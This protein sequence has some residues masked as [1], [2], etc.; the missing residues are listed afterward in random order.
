GAEP[1]VVAGRGCTASPRRARAGS[2][3]PRTA[4]R[5]ARADRPA[6][7]DRRS[8]ALP[9]PSQTRPAFLL[10][11]SSLSQPPVKSHVPTSTAQIARLGSW[12]LWSWDLSRRVDPAVTL[13][14][15]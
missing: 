15:E 13:G 6:I 14:L 11:A 12:E 1:P 7:W 5:R 4:P 9:T 3:A 8:A 10:V 2:R